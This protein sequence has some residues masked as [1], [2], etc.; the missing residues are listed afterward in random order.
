[1][2]AAAFLVVATAP[3]AP[4]SAEVLSGAL[5]TRAAPFAA[6]ATEWQALKQ[7]WRQ[8]GLDFQANYTGAVF[9]NL[10]GGVQRGTTY[11]DNIDLQLT[12]DAERLVGWPGATLFLYGLGTHGD[13]PSRDTG[14]AQGV[15]NIAA[16]Q[17]WTLYECWIQQNF[18]ANRL[19]LLVGRYDLN[20]EFYMLHSAGLFINSSF[21]IGPEFS[22]SGQ[23]GPS[24]FPNTAVGARLT[25]KPLQ[26]LQFRAAI[27]DGVPVERPGGARTIFHTGDG[28]LLVGEVD[29]LIGRS[30]ESGTSPTPTRSS[31]QRFRIG[32]TS[33][34]PASAGK[35]ALGG[36]YYTAQFDDLSAVRA[37]GEP[38][39]R[40]GSGGLYLVGEQVV[41]QDD[42]HP[43][44]RLTLFGQGGFGDGRVNRFVAYTGGG[45]S[46][47]APLPGRGADEAGLAVAAA[48]NGSHY[49]ERQRTEGMPVGNAEVTVELSYLAQLTTRL[50]LQPDIQYVINPNTDPRLDD[51]LVAAMELQLTL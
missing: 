11:L 8:E 3:A 47:S 41:Y 5:E 23:G 44:R 38:V 49:E 37:D 12:V 42:D 25:I 27:L 35:V 24:I 43:A 21:G 4:S 22:Q 48:Y 2:A 34:P 20:T 33:S 31:S 1:M 26:G 6:V 15:S 14:D 28:L 46:I 7:N 50:A 19:S 39:E 51:A 18:F 30:V 9:G 36:W 32:R 16:P 13:N 17:Q 29:H 10:S 40:R 45:L